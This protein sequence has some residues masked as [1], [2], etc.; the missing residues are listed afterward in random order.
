[1]A[2]ILD[3]KPK[4][5]ALPFGFKQVVTYVCRNCEYEW[6]GPYPFIKQACN[7]CGN[8]EAVTFKLETVKQMPPA[9]P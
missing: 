7:N 8:T 6:L 1:M 5:P 4:P 9:K 2:K 3:H